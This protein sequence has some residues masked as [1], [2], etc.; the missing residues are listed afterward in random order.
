MEHIALPRIEIKK[1]QEIWSMT[2]VIIAMSFNVDAFNP[3]FIFAFAIVCKILH[4]A[5]LY[6]ISDNMSIFLSA[7]HIVV[8]HMLE[9]L[10]LI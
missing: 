8:M 4:S 10:F 2:M 3:F 9:I 5:L 1:P 7:L 6:I